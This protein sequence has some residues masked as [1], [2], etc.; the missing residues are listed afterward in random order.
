MK[1]KEAIDR[2][3]PMQWASTSINQRLALLEQTRERLKERGQALAQSDAAMKNGRM[4]EDI[5]G[6]A[7]SKVGTMVPVANT[8][9][10][11]IHLY[12]SL[13]KG[14]MPKPVNIERVS[15][16][17]Y[18]VQVFPKTT[19]E[20][21]FAGA[22]K[23]FLY[24]K[25]EPKQVNPMDK[26]AGI[27]GVL[28]AGNY[29][30]SLE[31]V[32]ALFFENKAVVHKPHPLNEKTD[33]IW[34]DIFQPLIDMGAM[35]F[36]DAD[37]G[38]ALTKDNRLTQIYFT[39]G[40]KTAEAI[41]KNTKVPV[42]SECGGNNPCIVVPGDRP[43]SDKEMAHQAVQIATMAK[44]NG[45]AVCGRPQTVITAKG[46]AQREEFLAALREAI[47]VATPS[48][49][50]Y[51]PASI[52][53]WKGFTDAYPDAEVL[54]PEQG[55]F[56]HGK[57]LLVTDAEPQSYAATNE[58]FCQVLTE[59]P[60]EGAPEA[61][62]FLP[63]AVEFCNESLLGTLAAAI[64]VDEETKKLHQTVI[65]QAVLML[66]YGS[67]SVNT[68]PPFVFFSP[69]LTW[70]GNEQRDGQP[71]VS[72]YGNFGNLLGF[73]QVEKS[74]LIDSFMSA[75]HMLNT[76]KKAMDVMSNGMVRY[77]VDPSWM[78]L[79]RLVG[80]AIAGPHHSKDF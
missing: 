1:A 3:D 55:R 56:E 35:S 16:D 61:L 78:N 30:S 24:I 69:Y 66:N 32:K 18:R 67:V 15:K 74:V 45:G 53:T 44:M 19:K 10:A 72:G 6:I 51:Y 63:K 54:Q 38:K 14:H 31:M 77:A 27:I 5:F 73:E 42:V 41:M 39:G 26:P 64:L 8:L 80:G 21:I 22:Q 58:A 52:H 20:K 43:W 33:E 57:F 79:T 9:T 47:L 71:F 76:S 23:A 50:S 13:A 4:N 29:S 68:M 36:C 7:E 12:E 37:Q 49:G 60:L 28:G 70:G 65:D 17:H 75:G 25:G 11:A 34:A 59:I 2:L 46:W 62:T 48:A 40:T